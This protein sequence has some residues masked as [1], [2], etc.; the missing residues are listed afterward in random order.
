MNQRISLSFGGPS[1]PNDINTIVGA[2]L[3]RKKKSSLY[4][5]QNSNYYALTSLLL[6]P[7]INEH[8]APGLG[9]RR[10]E[11]VYVFEHGPTDVI[12][13]ITLLLDYH[14]NNNIIIMAVYVH[15]TKN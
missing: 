1:Y 12:I 11:Y 6:I 9:G 8:R 7:S 3:L 13:I 5:Q 4:M 14:D 2:L 10:R 15:T